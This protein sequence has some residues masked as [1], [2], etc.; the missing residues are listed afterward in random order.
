MSGAFKQ[1]RDG[2]VA[3]LQYL[4]SWE[5]NPPDNL[6]ND[7]AVFFEGQTEARDHYAFGEEI[8]HGVIQNSAAIDV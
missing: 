2:R 8:I 4:Y 1:R 5:L 6:A 3:A 7:L